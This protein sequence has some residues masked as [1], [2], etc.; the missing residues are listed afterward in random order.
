MI[1]ILP[2]GFERNYTL[3]F[4]RGLQANAVPLLVLSDDD[5]APALRAAGVAQINARGSV[6]ENRP[7]WRKAANLLRYYAWTCARLWR[8]RGGV[9]HFT[10]MFQNGRILFEGLA[11]N[12]A[13]RLAAGRYVYTVHNV[14]PHGRER[15]RFFRRV[16]RLVYRLPHV[17]LVHTE[18]ARQQLVEEFGVPPGKIRLT[19]I[20]LNEE[21]PVTALTPAAARR[22][23]GLDPGARALLFFGKIDE[24]K[25]LDRLLDAF[26]QL[27][28]PSTRLVV[29]GEFRNPACRTAILRQLENLRR[30]GD[31]QL[32][33]RFIPNEE[34]EVFF[35]ACDVLC[36]PYRH[37]YQSGLVFLGP[38]F[39]LPLVTTDVGSLR[40]FVEGS[41]L[42]LVSRTNDSAG[43]AEALTAFFA[44]S[45][46][47]PRGEIA[48][49]AQRYRWEEVCRTLLPLY[50]PPRSTQSTF[51]AT[52]LPPAHTG[53]PRP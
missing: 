15:S 5:V 52:S 29:A 13:L 33:E 11:L 1:L 53:E 40:E 48:A 7:A 16:Y 14:L 6:A 12:F 21:M 4:V 31:V 3:G 23:L 19:S 43:L 28:L 24:Y 10:G 20:G 49:K 42:G 44:L 47:F 34:A 41:G 37:I 27:D 18:R 35:K 51:V 26:D 8:H 22:R 38:R 30:R 45:G 36:L 9:V 50:T 32:H 2:N 17:L 25:G 39:G 46:R